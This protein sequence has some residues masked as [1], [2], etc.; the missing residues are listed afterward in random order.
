MSC[1]CND[2]AF[3]YSPYGTICQPDTPYPST[4]AESVPSLINNLTYS[5]YGQITKSVSNGQV[6]WTIPCDPNQ[7][8]SINGLTRNTGE[9]LLCYI[10]RCLNTSNTP[11]P[12]Y[13]TI[14]AGNFIANGVITTALSQGAFNYG[15]LSYSDVGLVESYTA[16]INGYVQSVLQNTS[17]GTSASTDFIVSN[18]SGTA[19]TYYGDFGING[20]Y[21]GTFSGTGNIGTGGVASN[22]LTIT[23]VTNG[24][25]A[26]GSQISGSGVTSAT[27]TAIL[28]GSGG[29]G[30][31]TINGS[32]QLVP[33]TTISGTPTGSLSLPNATY[34][35]SQS[36]DL[37]IGTNTNNSI[38]FV[39]NAQTTDAITI[40]SANAVGFNGAFG[41]SGSVLTTRGSNNTPQWTPQA[42]LSVGTATNSTN[43]TN[44]TGNTT[45]SLPYQSSSGTTSYLTTATAG[46]ILVSGASSAPSWGTDH[47]GNTSGTAVASG[48]VGEVIKL[49]LGGSATL[50]SNTTATLFSSTSLPA[51]DW[52]LYGTASVIATGLSV[53]ANSNILFGLTNVGGSTAPVAGQRFSFPIITALTTASFGFEQA[54]PPIQYLQTTANATIYLQ[55]SMPTFTA[56]SAT[57]NANI[58]ARRMR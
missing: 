1:G 13:T 24:T 39:T 23:A 18:N 27:I 8:A 47:I 12:T 58:W 36:G 20:S 6:V 25:L 17:A 55:Y 38:H 50:N 51:G 54:L 52:E 21:F 53:A 43:A 40:N 30:T 44:L 14:T 48:Y 35:Y 7:T 22:T 11:T 3:G 33:A 10:L 37:S 49:T 42:S 5:L 2:N 15:T 26:V 57:G 4:S 31:Y 56:G 16:A 9:G 34:L 45:G 19:T 28:T 41:S 46:Q 32:A 29:V